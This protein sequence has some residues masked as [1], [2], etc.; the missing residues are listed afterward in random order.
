[1]SLTECLEEIQDGEF[2][3][4]RCRELTNITL[5]QIAYRIRELTEEQ[6]K[7]EA[8]LLNALEELLTVYK[9]DS[10]IIHN[11][12]VGEIQALINKFKSEQ[13]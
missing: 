7:R 13:S 3:W 4:T 8:Q 5:C 6:S 2:A 12:V 1:M 10:N 9:R 11:P